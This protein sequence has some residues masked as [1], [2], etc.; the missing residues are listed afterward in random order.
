MRDVISTCDTLGSINSAEL[1]SLAQCTA[2]KISST[3]YC[4]DYSYYNYFYSSYDYFY[5]SDYYDYGGFQYDQQHRLPHFEYLN[6]VPVECR[7]GRWA[8]LEVL[9]AY[10][11][12]MHK[13]SHACKEQRGMLTDH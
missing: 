8:L 2:S 10:T 9:D 5:G 7:D 13:D 3:L 4:S 6:W 12:P 11:V 1:D